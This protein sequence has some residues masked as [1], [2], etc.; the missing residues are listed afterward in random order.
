LNPPLQVRHIRGLCPSDPPG[1]FQSRSATT[2]ALR[3]VEATASARRLASIAR[4]R[5][6]SA[7]ACTSPKAV[8]DKQTNKQTNKQADR[9]E[10]KRGKDA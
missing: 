4:T 5:A 8:P 9:P 6:P 7:L 3:G 2:L 10:K 1:L